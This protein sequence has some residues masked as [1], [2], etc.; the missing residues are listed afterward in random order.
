MNK[1]NTMK[2][3]IINNVL[4]D[5]TYGMVAIKAE[6]LAKARKFFVERFNDGSRECREF[7]KEFDVAIKNEDYIVMDLA[8]TDQSA[9]GFVKVMWGS[10]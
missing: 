4:S 7:K 3:F 10:S 1:G 5:Y 9:A 8:D 6:T 2:L